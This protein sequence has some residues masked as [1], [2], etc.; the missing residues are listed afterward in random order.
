M[1]RMPSSAPAIAASSSSA[2]RSGSRRPPA[3]PRCS[4][5]GDL[6]RRWQGRLGLRGAGPRRRTRQHED[7]PR[8]ADHH[9]VA[10]VQQHRPDATA[11]H[12]GAVAR[13]E[14][15]ARRYPSGVFS[16]MQ[17]KRLASVSETTTL[18]S[19]WSP[20]EI[21]WSPTD[22]LPVAGGRFDVHRPFP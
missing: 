14:V 22:Q 17:W 13:A 12:A 1:S 18:L 5:G 8:L 11:V 9:H 6:Q 7:Q 4:E 10:G 3:A 16:T 21:G 19:L 15:A 2:A 20:I